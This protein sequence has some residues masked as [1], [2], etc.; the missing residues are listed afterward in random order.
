MLTNSRDFSF[1]AASFSQSVCRETKKT[2]QRGDSPLRKK[3]SITVDKKKREKS[4]QLVSPAP[5]CK[6]LVSRGEEGKQGTCH[7]EEKEEE[8]RRH[9]MDFS[10]S[11]KQKNETADRVRRKKNKRHARE[12]KKKASRRLVVRCSRL[13]CTDTP[14]HTPHQMEGVP[15]FN[16]SDLFRL[17]Q[18]T[19]VSLALLLEWLCQ[20]EEEELGGV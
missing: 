8:R 11:L 7:H 19:L 16:F 6:Y 3:K 15:L 5:L 12:E 9:R 14:T 17:L 4:Q 10:S 18:L 20:E 1:S 13:K 2:Q